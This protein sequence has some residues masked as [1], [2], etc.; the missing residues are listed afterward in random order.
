MNLTFNSS[1]FETNKTNITTKTT[2]VSITTFLQQTTTTKYNLPTYYSRVVLS[3]QIQDLTNFYILPAVCVIGCVLTLLKIIVLLR[4]TLT[5]RI[6][7]FL[8]VIAVTDFIKLFTSAFLILFRCGSLC[9]YGYNYYAKYYEQY[10]YLYT[11]NVCTV[12]GTCI[13]VVAVS[14]RLLSFYPNLSKRAERSV[15]FRTKCIVLLVFSVL[16]N[17]PEYV[18]TRSVKELGRLVVVITT[19]VTKTATAANNTNTMNMTTTNTT[20]SL[21]EY[22]TLYSV[23]N[24]DL[25]KLVAMKTAQFILNIIRKL[26]LLILLVILN[27][28]VA[29]KFKQHMSKKRTITGKKS[30]SHCLTTMINETR[31]ANMQQNADAASTVLPKSKSNALLTKEVDKVSRSE[32]AVTKM[33]LLTCVACFFGNILDSFTA[34]FFNILDTT[35]YYYHL[36]FSSLALFSVHGTDFFLIY[37]FNVNFRNTFKLMFC[38]LTTVEAQK[39]TMTNGG[40]TS[41]TADRT[42]RSRI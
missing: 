3:T 17:L 19:T 28:L 31:S 30:S 16:I 2:K 35:S 15:S 40:P 21:V 24:N 26:A 1:L 5:G 22:E 38:C 36:L 14:D 12:Y 9:P 13:S 25:G 4:R 11:G 10:I 41:I 27:L 20:S 23:V 7:Q 39:L 29:I 8:L 33:I 32:Q 37:F 34:I 18:L 42:A 6:Y